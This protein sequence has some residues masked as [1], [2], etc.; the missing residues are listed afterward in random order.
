MRGVLHRA[1]AGSGSVW[2]KGGSYRQAWEGL[3]SG[4]S[5]AL[6]EFRDSV[7]D[8]TIG[9]DY[10]FDLFDGVQDRGVIATSEE[11]TDARE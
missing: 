5:K 6:G 9:L 1:V 2:G 3:S 4:A 10:P 8:R 11:G 7:V